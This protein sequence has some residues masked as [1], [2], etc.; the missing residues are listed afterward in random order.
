MNLNAFKTL[1]LGSGLL[2]IAGPY[3]L[4]LLMNLFGCVGDDPLT[5][6]VEVA[7]CT[8]GDLFTI[9]VG[10]QKVI[11]GI[12]IAGALALSGFF[13]TGT[14]MQNLFA[15]SVPVVP[16]ADAKPGVVTIGQVNSTKP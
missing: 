15:P 6:A 8:G 7:Q 10:L 5:A 4:N 14:F 2:A 11:G 13:K 16:A 12:V 9:P 1:F 3:L